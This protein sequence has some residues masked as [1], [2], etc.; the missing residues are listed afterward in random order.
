MK[1]SKGL[2]ETERIPMKRKDYIALAIIAVLFLAVILVVNSVYFSD[3]KASKLYA[4]D[5]TQLLDPNNDMIRQNF[6]SPSNRVKGFNIYVQSDKPDDKLMVTLLDIETNDVTT[7]YLGED[8]EIEAD[9]RVYL[10]LG[11][12]SLDTDADYYLYAWVPEGDSSDIKIVAGNDKRNGYGSSDDTGYVWRYQIVYDSMSPMIVVIE[13]VCFLLIIGAFI[14]I[15]ENVKLEIVLSFIYFALALMFFIITPINTLYDEEG[16]FYRSYEVASG[17]MVSDKYDNGMGKSS[18]PEVMQLCLE[19]ITQTLD[20]RGACFIYKRQYDTMERNIDDVMVD[21]DNPNQ[22][23]YSPISYLPQALGLGIARLCISNAFLFYFYGR[24][25]AFIVNMMLV[26]FAIKLFPERKGLIFV[27]AASP[28]FLAQMVSYSA[29][30]TLNS[31]ALFFVALVMHYTKKEKLTLKDKIFLPVLCV[32]IALSKMIYFPF[33]FLI[34]L[35]DNKKIAEKKNGLIYK[36]CIIAASVIAFAAWYVVARGYLFNGFM[37]SDVRPHEQTMYLLSHFYMFPVIVLRTIY[38]DIFPWIGQLSGAGVGK[39]MLT[40]D[41]IIWL[42]FTVLM[43]IELFTYRES[44]LEK[45]KKSKFWIILAA[46]LVILGLTFASLYVQWTPYQGDYVEGIQGRYFIPLLLP[47][48]LILSRK[49]IQGSVKNRTLMESIVI[50]SSI[51]CALV[52]T[53]YLYV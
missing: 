2:Y 21:V 40:L 14:T 24:F 10:D 30:G 13:I 17:H 52:N 48:S 39:G 43:G 44:D 29:D 11:D 41:Y 32:V 45:A 36:C 3:Y 28:V 47:L 33:V 20:N 12:I 9:G 27:V 35:I 51:M 7:W 31:L 6:S 8:T 50:I 37:G 34:L 49:K 16:H 46:V 18:V 26:F 42:P 25:F 5:E 53:Y 22:S 23:L 4:D 15:R 19:N 38:R 1:F